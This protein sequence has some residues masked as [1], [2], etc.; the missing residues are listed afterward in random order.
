MENQ[1]TPCKKAELQ[2]SNQA[3]ETPTMMRAARFIRKVLKRTCYQLPNR[4]KF[5][6]MDGKTM[7][8]RKSRAQAPRSLRLRTPGRCR[9]VA[10]PNCEA[11]FSLGGSAI[12]SQTKPAF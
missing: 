12:E 2:P 6:V 4:V 7:R 8:F 9:D 11:D 10:R 3:R 1:A 5:F